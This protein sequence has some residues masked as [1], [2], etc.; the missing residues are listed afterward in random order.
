M[1]Q[2]VS[3]RIF[4]IDGRTFQIIGEKAVELLARAAPAAEGTTLGVVG[5]GAVIGAAAVVAASPAVPV[6]REEAE[7]TGAAERTH[8]A[9]M[10]ANAH[11]A[12]VALPEPSPFADERFVRGLPTQN[13]I[14][15]GEDAFGRSHSPVPEAGPPP[16]TRRPI[17]SV[18]KAG[19]VSEAR[20]S[21]IDYRTTRDGVAA[22][23]EI[24]KCR[25]EFNGF[26]SQAELE[27]SLVA[28]E[29]VSG[30]QLHH[31]VEQRQLNTSRFGSEVVQ[32]DLNALYL[33][34]DVH[35]EI[36]AEMAR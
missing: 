21:Y 3:P 26:R 16:H 28:K 23:A 1:D 24:D 30:W 17:E 35:Q 8:R 4:V 34:K 6:S 11:G 22:K 18:D 12:P 13:Q 32:L 27:D 19:G 14:D 5:A 36:T 29:R 9:E 10:I 7:R 2:P 25:P 31:V 33:P 15:K 20:P